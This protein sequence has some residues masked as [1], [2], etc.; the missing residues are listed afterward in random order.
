[1]VLLFHLHHKDFDN[2]CQAPV[3]SLQTQTFIDRQRSPFAE[4][5]FIGSVTTISLHRIL[6][7]TSL[8]MSH[9]RLLG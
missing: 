9:Q 4:N 3:A 2:L 1:L 6:V 8:P 5:L 7:A